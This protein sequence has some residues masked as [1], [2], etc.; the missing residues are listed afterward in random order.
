MLYLVL[1]VGD[2]RYALDARQIVEILPLVAVSP[3]PRAPEG[4]AGVI[5]YRG[6]PVPAV[7]LCQLIYGRPSTRR[8][9][10]RVVIVRRA[11]QADGSPLFGLIVE[12]AAET[13]R[14]NADE[15]VDAGVGS[16]LSPYLG[17][18][19][20]DVNGLVRHFD[21]APLLGRP[22]SDTPSSASGEQRWT[23]T[24]SKAS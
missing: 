13:M 8:R 16:P 18:V 6:A 19:T 11:E 20:R 2:D 1:H 14:R 4:V 22:A 5:E 23:W 3:L 7:D 12:K 21:P 15:F 10:T 17:A 9:G 24:T